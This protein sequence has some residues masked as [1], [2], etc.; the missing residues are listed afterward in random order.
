MKETERLEVVR[1]IRRD[2]EEKTL[3]KSYCEKL[4]QLEDDPRVKEY[5]K[6]MEEIERIKKDHRFFDDSI[7]KMINMEFIWAF[8]S[9]IKGESMSP[10]KHEIWIYDGS[11]YLS[12]VLF[13]EHEHELITKDENGENF[14]YNRYTCLECGKTV[15]VSNWREFEDTHFVLKDQQNVRIPSSNYSELYY[16]Y[17]LDN[18]VE[19]AQEKI[20]EEFNKRLTM[21][22]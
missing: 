1:R 12:C 4:I 19:D 21:E 15:K 6:T 17:L 11:Y 10:C 8:Q 13:S 14:D 22:K 20:I 9:R 5:L 3:L 7:D 16:K 2:I 18:S